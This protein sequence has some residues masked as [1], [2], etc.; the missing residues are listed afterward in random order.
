M[1]KT[2]LNKQMSIAMIGFLERL[3]KNIDV[4]I[5]IV[6]NFQTPEYQKLLSDINADINTVAPGEYIGYITDTLLGVGS[7]DSDGLLRI[8]AVNNGGVKVLTKVWNEKY[9]QV[10]T[11]KDIV[12]PPW[13]TGVTSS[14]LCAVPLTEANPNAIEAI[15]TEEGHSKMQKGVTYFTAVVS[16]LGIPVG[17]VDNQTLTALATVFVLTTPERKYFYEARVGNEVYVSTVTPSSSLTH[18]WKAAGGTDQNAVETLIQG[19]IATSIQAVDKT[20]NTSL[21]SPKAFSVAFDAALADWVGAAPEALDTI[22]EIAAAFQN[23]PDI[24]NVMMTLISDLRTDTNAVTADVESIKGSVAG[25][26]TSLNALTTKVNTLET[27]LTAVTERV[28]NLENATPGGGGG[29]A[30]GVSLN[31]LDMTVAGNNLFNNADLKAITP[32]LYTVELVEADLSNFEGYLSNVTTLPLLAKVSVADDDLHLGE[33]IV[34]WEVSDGINT[35]QRVYHTL[36]SSGDTVKLI[37]ETQLNLVNDATYLDLENSI[38]RVGYEVGGVVSTFTGKIVKGGPI[39]AGSQESRIKL[40]FTPTGEILA[41]SPNPVIQA[42]LDKIKSYWLPYGAVATEYAFKYVLGN[43]SLDALNT[44]MTTA[45]ADMAGG[46]FSLGV[47]AVSGNSNSASI[48]V[49]IKHNPTGKEK[50]ISFTLQ[51]NGNYFN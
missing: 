2:E 45:Y 29:T 22:Q 8:T 42:E 41:V 25:F 49:Y 18:N 27:S 50:M 46:T 15:P 33:R 32:G 23:D 12:T 38:S 11:G 39:A 24:L 40:Q 43:G 36:T 30:S 14:A 20:N 6:D 47:K 13:V 44:T 3:Q 35:I 9:Q 7:T 28:T 10:R 19:L 37:S 16:E 48:T 17:I 26:T 51:A 4:P 34:K 5:T 21:M 31:Y 1:V